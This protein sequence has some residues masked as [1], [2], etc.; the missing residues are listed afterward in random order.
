MLGSEDYVSILFFK[1][2]DAT[3]ELARLS[4]NIK[5]LLFKT[6]PVFFLLIVALLGLWLNRAVYKTFFQDIYSQVSIVGLLVTA[7]IS[8]IM[9][10]KQGASENYYFL[11]TFFITF[12]SFAI[13]RQVNVLSLHRAYNQVFISVGWALSLFAVL[14]VLT[15]KAGV[16]STRSHHE[17]HIEQSDCLKGSP[18]PLLPYG[19]TYLSLPWMTNSEPRF[20]VFYNY[21][22][23]RVAGRW[24]EKDGVGGLINEGYFGTIVQS[25]GGIDNIDSA[26]LSKN[27][28]LTKFNCAGLD[29]YLRKTF[30]KG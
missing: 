2:T 4:I 23:D 11:L 26:P 9:S 28:K 13:L 5:N 19:N 6:T 10:A 21:S 29:I 16:I 30:I 7:P 14:L 18:G 24:F 17:R 12:F 1:G 8:I 20:N 3:L 25:T 22:R 27:Y 15:G